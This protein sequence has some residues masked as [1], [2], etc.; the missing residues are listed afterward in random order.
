MHLYVLIC[1]SMHV[2][3]C[4]S[5]TIGAKYN[6]RFLGKTTIL[7]MLTTPKMRIR[8]F[9]LCDFSFFSHLITIAFEWRRFHRKN[10][11]VF[12]VWRSN[13]YFYLKY[14]IF[15]VLW[16]Y[17]YISMFLKFIDACDENKKVKTSAISKNSTVLHN[18]IHKL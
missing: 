13:V 4:V 1:I 2:Y 14:L 12:F 8:D 17:C 6:N 7:L 5:I 10:I 15:Q 9:F 16:K 11:S 3:A 18:Y